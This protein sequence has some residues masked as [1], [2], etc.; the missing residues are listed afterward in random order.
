MI[1]AEIPIDEIHDEMWAELVRVIHEEA[2]TEAAECKMTL[3][4]YL[5]SCYQ[6]ERNAL[7]VCNEIDR[8]GELSRELEL[9]DDTVHPRI[10]AKAVARSDQ[11]ADTYGVMPTD[12]TVS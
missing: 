5:K 9:Y 8:K 12:P 11:D 10:I 2:P 3:P 6:V 7:W 4:A 1:D